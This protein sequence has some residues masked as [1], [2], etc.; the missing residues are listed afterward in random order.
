MLIIMSGRRVSPEIAHQF[1]MLPPSFLPLGQGRLYSHQAKLALGERCI[2]TLPDDYEISSVDKAMLDQSNI[3]ILQQPETLPIRGAIAGVLDSLKPQENVRILYGDTLVRMSN[4]DLLQGDIV[5][6]KDSTANYLWAFAECDDTG[7]LMRFSEDPPK[8]QSTRRIVS[9]YFNFSDPEKLHAA[10]VED[11]ITGALNSYH[12]NKGLSLTEP[13]EWYDF[14]HLPLY[15]RSKRDM[16]TARSF[17]EVKFEDGYTVK[18]S[19][20]VAKIRAEANWY[21][22]IPNRLRLHTPRYLGRAE[23]D[24]QAGYALEYVHHPLLADL[25]VFGELSLA[26][27]LEIL[28][29]CIDFLQECRN[30]RPQEFSPEASEEFASDFF[31]DMYVRKTWGR[32]EHFSETS[33]ISLNQQITVNGTL[34]PSIKQVVTELLAEIPAT[35]PDD[36]CMWHGDFFFGNIFYDFTAGRVICIDPRG[37]LSSGEQSL[38]GDYRYDLGKLAHSI[39]GKYD[40]IV[41]GRSVLDEHTGFDWSIAVAST[42]FDKEV[43]EIFFQQVSASFGLQKTELMAHMGLLFFTMLPLHEEAPQR[44]KM[45]LCSGLLAYARLQGTKT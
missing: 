25:H 45:L 9:G 29:G 38:Y 6:V 37:Q 15:F 16:L 30:L 8:Y 11:K 36:I 26:N 17:N 27:W 24:Y 10:C 4:E 39:L 3:E 40:K 28:R 14:G 42:S 18:R 31:Q 22:N 20:K 41:L 23:G 7:A 43:E 32:L 21:E 12:Q 19:K 33:G 35:S 5:A 2:L 13:E 34:L 44:Q 1:G